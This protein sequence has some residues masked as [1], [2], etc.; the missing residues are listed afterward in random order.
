M[1]T[2]CSFPPVADCNA[3]VL[4]LG[5][6]PG[7]ASLQAGQYY[8][9]PRNAFWPI[10]AA[11]LDWPSG[12]AYAERLAR[13]RAARIAL[14]DVLQSCR[15]D[16]SLDAAI[17]DTSIVPND[18][19]RFLL[20]HTRITHV[21]FNGSKAESAFRRY[22]LPELFCADRLVC[23]R[24]PST[25]PAHAARGFDEKLRAWRRVVQSPCVDPSDRT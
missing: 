12:V 10:L 21:F 13:L 1:T 6:M 4:I 16:G 22:V 15:R 3:R 25:S 2:V 24:L 18:F 17:D 5:S 11:L 14:W 20:Q 8:A 19:G 7:V 9:H 23:E